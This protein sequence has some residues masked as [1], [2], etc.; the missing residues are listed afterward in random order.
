MATSTYMN[1][2]K[3]YG[4]PQAML[5]SENSG[6]L[7]NGLYIPNGLEINANPGSEVD[8]YNIDLFLN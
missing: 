6:K 8:P 3:K 4:R 1:G 5:W 7:E 2:R